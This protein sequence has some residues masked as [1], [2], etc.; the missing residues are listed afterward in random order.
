MITLLLKEKWLKNLERLSG[1]E[2]GSLDYKT[3]TIV[4]EEQKKKKRTALTKSYIYVLTTVNS[5]I[6]S[7]V[8]RIK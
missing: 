7:L 1:F 8:V 2:N 5:A 3:V 4:K 6:L